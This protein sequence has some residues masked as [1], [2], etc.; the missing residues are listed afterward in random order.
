MGGAIFVQNDGT[1]TIS[2]G[3]AFTGSSVIGGAGLFGGIHDG[4]AFGQ[5]L[6]VRSGGLVVF[7]I[8]NS[9]NMSSAISSDEGAGGGTGGGLTKTGSGIV[10]LNGTN[11]YSGG[12]LVSAGTLIVNGSIR[13]NVTINSQATLAGNLTVTN[14]GSVTNNGTLSP[15]NSIGTVVITG[16]YTQ[17]S[18]GTLQIEIDPSGAS[19]LLQVSNTASLNGTLQVLPDPGTYTVGTTYTILTANPVTGTFSTVNAKFLQPTVDFEV[20]YSSSDVRLLITQRAF[21]PLIALQPSPLATII[22]ANVVGMVQCMDTMDI[23]PQGD[24]RTMM[25]AMNSLSSIPNIIIAMNQ[26]QPSMFTAL[27]LVQESDGL[28]VRSAFTHRLQ[29]L[30]TSPC[31][32]K[33][34]KTDEFNVWIEPFGDF[35]DEGIR[36][37]QPGFDTRGGG[38]VIGSDFRPVKDFYIGLGTAYTFSDVDWRS[39]FGDGNINSYYGGLYTT[40]RPEEYFFYIDA[41]FISAFNSYEGTRNIKFASINRKAKNHHQGYELAGQLGVGALL[42]VCG[43]LFQPFARGEYIFLHEGDYNERGAQAFDLHIKSKNSDL[44]RGEIGLNLS[45][46]ITVAPVKL[47]P[48]GHISWIHETRHKGKHLTA[49]FRV[50]PSCQFTVTGMNPHR[51]LAAMGVGLTTLLA[52]DTISVGVLYDSE[53][54]SRYFNNTFN[55][56]AGFGF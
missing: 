19:D 4:G 13:D 28:R 22:M 18:G 25:N 41:S 49:N 50:L 32:E 35:S 44:W 23:N 24:I 48:S 45:G 7:N 29:E 38:V 26:M 43:C 20:L 9:L 17:G 34:S 30:Y 6:F 31:S 3:A 15:G 39:S 54:G 36:N 46:C 12:T 27:A 2:D 1:V 56:H 53:F 42:D 55:V 47:I 11:T 10:T 33:W 16:N 51:N 37:H 21:V 5:D 14:S 52:D 40:W 8:N